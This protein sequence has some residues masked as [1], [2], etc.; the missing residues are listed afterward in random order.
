VRD[1]A[2]ET[3]TFTLDQESTA[4]LKA[5]AQ[6][7]GSTLYMTLLSVFSVFL[8][9]VSGQEDIIIGTPVAG[10]SHEE[11]HNTAG[12]F[13]NTLPL[14]LQPKGESTF[15]EFLHEVKEHSLEAFENQDYQ[16]EKLID[17]LNLARDTARNP[18][19]DVMFTLQN[20]EENKLALNGLSVLSGDTTD[21]VAK[22]DL[23][24]SAVDVNG[25][26]TLSFEF[27]T[28]LF[29]RETI[30][31]F[32]GYLLKIIKQVTQDQHV[33]IAELNLLSDQE[34]DHVLSLGKAPGI[35]PSPHTT[36][37]SAFVAQA[38]KTPDK[39]AVTYGSSA[40]TYREVDELSGQIAA[41]ITKDY[42]IRKGSLVGVMLNRDLYTFPCIL[43]ILKAGAAY[44]PVDPAYPEQRQR[45]I[46]SKASPGL[47]IG[48]PEKENTA[49]PYLDLESLLKDTGKYEA[50]SHA[51]SLPDCT[52][53]AYI[54]FTSGS[55]GEPKGV[56]IRHGSLYGIT[57]SMQQQFPMS[58]EDS[59][60]LKTSL[61][62]DVSCSE[63]FAWFH[64]GGK[65]VILPQGKEGN[66][67][68]IADTIQQQR[69]T[70]VN[71]VPSMFSVF[72]DT[73]KQQAAKVIHLKYI[74]LA[75]E[76]LGKALVESASVVMGDVQMVNVYGPTEATI[77]CTGTLVR[78]GSVSI[79]KPLGNNTIYILD[80]NGK[81]APYG[82]AGQLCIA[83]E[84]LAEGYLNRPDLTADK[85]SADHISGEGRIYYTG[86]LAR[87]RTDGT[88]EYLG[89]LDHQV[90]VRGFRIELGEIE[91]RMMRH[92]A[93]DEAVVKVWD[94]N[95]EKQIAAYYTSKVPLEKKELKSCLADQLPDYMIPAFFIEIDRIPL[96]PNGKADLKALPKPE[97][98]IRE[99]YIAPVTS[100]EQKL[101]LI[102]LDILGLSNTCIS[103]DVDFFTI[104][105]HSLSATIMVNKIASLFGVELP[106]VEVF[107]SPTISEISRA[108][109]R[110][111]TAGHVSERITLL[112]RGNAELGGLFI[113]HD[114]SGDIQ[115]YVELAAEFEPYTIWGLR[116]DSLA[117]LGPV[118][119]D[120]THLARDYAERIRVI[121]PQGP[122]RLA[123]W[124][125]GGTIAFEVARQL[126]AAGEVVEAVI[127]IDTHFPHISEKP[128][129]PQTY[130]LNEEKEMLR[131][132]LKVRDEI[133]SGYNSI[134]ELWEGVLEFVVSHEES[135]KELKRMISAHFRQLIPHF[136]DLG[137]RNLI[138]QANTIRSLA[139]ATAQYIPV[140]SI[141]SP[142]IYM[143]ASDTDYYPAALQ[144]H[145]K[146]QL[147]ISEIEG[148]HFSIMKSPVV[149]KL[150]KAMDDMVIRLNASIVNE[151]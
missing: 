140:G 103:T 20:F 73:I 61:S 28:A 26:L 99:E 66:P 138:T 147:L 127:M 110:M 113:M 148:D 143:K 32:S 47:I 84:G 122:Y 23:S 25:Q 89:R 145:T 27:A 22:F 96:T 101:S 46:L 78:P 91:D 30:Q 111:G 8:H 34:R 129:E 83:G 64:A 4:A 136:D 13:V 12:L 92:A 115:G 125:M 81:L 106:L 17:E 54:I 126:E 42:G 45:E 63:L 62:F 39:I 93:V 105:G 37:V 114:G 15:S 72:L 130:S 88:I 65:L 137:I 40:F 2:G 52:D 19:F 6:D 95:G 120:V 67:M 119:T 43:G 97:I 11:L 151:L 1:S 107:K 35:P 60:L 18:L 59:F 14:R 41:C 102:W 104:G 7:S 86:D 149:Q 132:Q 24:L 150:A 109:D 142:I 108:I 146:S 70:H 29:H 87:W 58:S 3:E 57:A 16:Y 98:E 53:L 76:A 33:H 85:F 94:T 135:K 69:V 44:V 80:N 100:T 38:K 117:H 68:A 82:S 49:Q 121:Q 71:F 36:V 118:E 128:V 9:K 21:N 77:Y 50:V 139:D 31:R 51:D 48:H 90:K 74:F 141:E 10:R 112:R 56:M 116:S 123:G 5:L 75:G 79:G 124:S 134:E 144:K 131:E 133:L 55:T